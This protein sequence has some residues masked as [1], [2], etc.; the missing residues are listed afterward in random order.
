MTLRG[1]VRN[2]K[3]ENVR[4]KSEGVVIALC[5]H[6]KCDWKTFVGKKFLLEYGIDKKA[7]GLIIRMVSWAHCGTGMSRER[8]KEMNDRENGLFCLI[9][10]YYL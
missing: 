4:L 1:L 6:H 10:F 8:R 3:I 5:C 2:N 9:F 7:F